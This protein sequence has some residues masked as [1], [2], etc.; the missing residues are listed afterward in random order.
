MLAA[1]RSSIHTTPF[2]P[3][4]WAMLDKVALWSGT[5]EIELGKSLK[6]DS[7]N[8]KRNSFQL[9]WC[10]E[11][12]PKS[13]SGY[14]DARR[15]TVE[16]R[17]FRLSVIIICRWSGG[18][19]RSPLW[20]RHRLRY[21]PRRFD[22]PSG[23]LCCP[24]ASLAKLIDALL[25]RVAARGHKPDIVRELHRKYGPSISPTTPKIVSVSSDPRF[26]LVL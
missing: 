13:T 10:L 2:G 21:R 14:R 8:G 12:T 15:G 26:L 1:G 22:C 5:R 16:K 9:L 17:A 4:F 25:G 7:W 24:R 6:E 19:S 20:L 23:S 18:L 3:V 11:G